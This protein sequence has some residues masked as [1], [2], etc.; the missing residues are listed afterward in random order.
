MASLIHGPHLED[1]AL[2]W[3]LDHVSAETLA[4][5]V[6]AIRSPVGLNQLRRLEHIR[7][8]LRGRADSDQPRLLLFAGHG[9][10]SDLTSDASSRPDVDL[11]DLPRLYHG[12]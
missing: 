5:E 11:I 4:G 9:F 10:T 3:C 6:K 8:L 7:S 12:S 1:F 2:G